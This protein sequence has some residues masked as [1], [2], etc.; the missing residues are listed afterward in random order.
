M[1]LHRLLGHDQRRGDLDWSDM[2]CAS[3]ARTSFSR[4]SDPRRAATG[5][6]EKRRPVN[7]AI[8]RRV[9]DGASNASPAATIRTA[10]TNSAPPASLRRNPLAPAGERVV[11][12]LVEVERGQ[13]QHPRRR[14][15]ELFDEP[16]GRGDAVQHRHP[17]VHHDD[18]GSMHP[19][20]P[21]PR[22]RRLPSPPP[23]CQRG[24]ADQCG[25]TIPGKPLVV[26]HHRTIYARP[27]LPNWLT[28]KCAATANRASASG[29]AD[30]L[31][32]TAST[33]S[34][35]P[36]KPH[37]ATPTRPRSV[38]GT[39]LPTRSNNSAGPR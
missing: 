11:D 30:T 39:G 12:V 37:P 21:A 2:P 20:R 35:I 22:G 5:R 25:Q 23:R 6:R 33:R 4:G 27:P 26:G 9:T 14:R 17:D 1:A 8:R 19:R 29:P 15:A 31:P 13:H 32:P 36:R 24:R 18:I 10:R 3:R 34:R 38:H 16:R 7:S 28:G